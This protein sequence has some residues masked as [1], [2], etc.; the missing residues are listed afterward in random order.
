MKTLVA[1][2]LLCLGCQAGFAQGLR[3]TFSGTGD[4]NHIDWIKATNQNTMKSLT[5]PGKEPLWVEV[6]GPAITGVNPISGETTGSMIYPNPFQ[7]N[8][9]LLVRVDEPQKVSLTVMNLSGQV[10]ARTDAL[11]EAGS[12]EFSI[13]L[14][15]TGIYM[16]A[17][18]T[19]DGTSGIKAICTNAG[20]Q[21]TSVQYRGSSAI[22]PDDVDSRVKG[23]RI[24]ETL[25]MKQ[26]DIIL[27]EC[28]SGKMTTL[29][30][31]S[32]EADKDYTVR[33]VGC[34]DADGRSYPVV[35]L[36]NVAWMAENLAWLPEVSS[37]LNGSFESPFYYVYGYEG[38]N[39]STA[40]S[41]ANYSTYGALY[42]WKAAR[43]ACP[44]GWKLPSDKDWLKLEKYLGMD[45]TESDLTG[46][47]HSGEVGSL[48]KEPGFA[49]WGSAEPE[50]DSI[51]GFTA[52]PGGYVTVAV[53]DTCSV[54]RGMTNGNMDLFNFQRL[55]LCGFFW[56]STASD[57][58]NA[59][60]RRLGCS[61][62]GIER[63]ANP[64]S[65]GYSVRCVRYLAIDD[66]E[67]DGH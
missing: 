6:Y 55:G 17:V 30:T 56:T 26:G 65:Y 24:G 36:G 23:G 61:E 33:F 8:A 16:V 14:S 19:S 57:T 47:R 40:R 10:V 13:S 50:P 59:W 38:N 66:L 42:N 32:P 49:H 62:N 64:K 4:A 51:T 46:W 43:S 7:G 15:K 34:T 48:L 22:F 9:N 53:G 18:T 58:H 39:L 31:D 52:L 28:I 21:E 25:K 2:L 67:D 41:L 60:I 5:I 12:N 3:M 11:V 20:G 27:Y 54:G 44:K 29:M 37:P 1:Y 35:I 45:S 63:K